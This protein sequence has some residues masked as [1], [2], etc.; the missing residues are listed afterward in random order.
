M[1]KHF[2]GFVL[3]LVALNIGCGGKHISKNQDAADV[4]SRQADPTKGLSAR[5]NYFAKPAGA[6]KGYA[7]YFGDLNTKQKDWVYLRLDIAYSDVFGASSRFLTFRKWGEGLPV[8]GTANAQFMLYDSATGANLNFLNSSNQYTLILDYLNDDVVKSVIAYN[9]LGLSGITKDNFF[10]RIYLVLIDFDLRWDA[11]E[12]THADG[13]TLLER[14]SFLAPPFYANPN[15]Y[16][17]SRRD[18]AEKAAL[19][20]L[21]PNLA[22]KDSGLSDAD[23]FKFTQDNCLGFHKLEPGRCQ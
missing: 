20:A 19:V 17:S 8:S 18:T 10:Q 12:Y 9:G 6:L 14:Q 7:A 13:T 21:H 4:S 11:V 16:E 15:T 22:K 3:V 1:K 23:F 2:F 5:Y